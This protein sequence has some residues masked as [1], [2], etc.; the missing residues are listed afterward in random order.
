MSRNALLA[1]VSA[2]CLV[3][4]TANA[5][6]Q[7]QSQSATITSSGNV[8][9]ALTVMNRVVAHTQRLIETKNF[10]QLPRENEALM[11]GARALKGSIA[12]ESPE[13]RGKI[14]ALLTKADTG[15]KNLADASA[16][17]REPQLSSL[18]T[19]FAGSVRE[20]LAAFPSNV[21]PGPPSVADEKKEENNATT[22]SARY[23]WSGS[24]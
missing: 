9:K 17:A 8:Q 13:F 10:S 20:L 21:Q 5:P 2:L 19:A 4:T 6:A 16:G 23:P 22:G 12:I 11:D 18:H 7:T 1:S 24:I 15:S 3:F 14:E